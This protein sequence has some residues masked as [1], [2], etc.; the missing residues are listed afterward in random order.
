[1]GKKR[2]PRRDFLR[3]AVATTAA[4]APGSPGRAQQERGCAEGGSE[5]EPP[6]K[7]QGNNLNL[8]VIV[9]DTFRA[10]NLECYG[11]QWI[12]C[13]NLNQFAKESAIFEDCYAEGLPTIPVRRAL[14]TGRRVL[15]FHY[16]PQHE[17]V[18]SPGWH[19]LF[20]EDVTL[21]ETLQAA[22][23]ITT[24]VADLPHLQ[25]PDRNF[26]RGFSST[27]WIRGQ[28]ADSYGTVPH[29]LADVSDMASEEHLAQFPDLRMFLNY[30]KANRQLWLQEGEALSQI[31]METAIR[32]LKA[33]HDQRPFYL[34]IESFDPHEPWDPPARFLQKYL[35]HAHGP[36]FI[37][38]PYA[39]ATLPEPIKQRMRANYAGEATCVDFWVGKFLDTIGELGLFENSVVVFTTDHGTLLGEQEQ[40]L[41]GPRRLRGQ[42]THIPLLIRLPGKQY[43]AK[44]VPRYIQHPDL[45][46][47]FLSLLGLKPPSRV[48]GSN[49]WPLVTGATKSLRD[50]VEQA[51][52]WIAAVRTREWNY[53]QIWKPAAMRTSDYP[54]QLY[55]LEKDPRELARVASKYPEVTRQLSARLQEYLA[56]GEEITRGSFYAKESLGMGAVYVNT[57]TQK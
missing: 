46:P 42:V 6:A 10:D 47:T 1:M 11:S 12:E 33:N 16:Y 36:S 45:V 3:A 24:L 22:G 18:Q 32:W 23:Y 48:T 41:K 25:R 44:R 43:A 40:F 5:W 55:N 7:Q 35:P 9:C 8:I 30:Y 37:E 54:P 27:R 34:H 49:F 17:P 21:S 38:P 39:D 50:S 52:G 4:L 15:P 29:K 56:S 51:Y 53:S 20:N 14:Y 2:F 19:Q 13:P 28:E 31:V 57:K 26:H